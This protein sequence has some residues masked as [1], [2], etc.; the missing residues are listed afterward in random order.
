MGS[1]IS[2]QHGADGK[3]IYLYITVFVRSFV[4]RVSLV[5]SLRSG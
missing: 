2:T 5:L 1:V 3:C 4:V